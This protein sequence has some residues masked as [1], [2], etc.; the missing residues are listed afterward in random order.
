MNMNEFMKA[1]TQETGLYGQELY[2]EVLR[3][4]QHKEEKVQ[5]KERLN[6]P[7][8]DGEEFYGSLSELREYFKVKGG[9]DKM[10]KFLG[11]CSPDFAAAV[12]AG[13][14]G[15]EWF[16]WIKPVKFTD[17]TKRNWCYYGAYSLTSGKWDR[18]SDCAE[19][20]WKKILANNRKPLPLNF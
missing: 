14:L 6:Y 10:A 7:T 4:V 20:E 13:E 9:S 11:A 5:Q 17:G 2:Q 15:M 1:L 8:K 3:Q 19:E 12:V 16:A 18:F